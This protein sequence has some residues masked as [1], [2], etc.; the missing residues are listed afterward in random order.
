MANNLDSN[1]VRKLARIFLDKFEAARVLSKTVN[2]QLL[3]GK[4]NPASGTTT[5]FKRPTDYVSKRTSDGDISATDSSDIIAG[6]ATGTVQN[7][8]TVDVEWA[9][10]DEALKLDQL[11]ELLAP[12]AT[13]IVL[14]LETDFAAFM[15]ANAGLSTGSPDTSVTTWQHVANAG[16]LMKSVGIPADSP[17]HYAMNPFTQA[18]LANTNRALGSPVTGPVDQALTKATLIE[19]FAGM[20]VLAPSTL[21]TLTTTAISD[22]AGSLSAAPDVTYVTAKDSMTQSWAVTGFTAS[23]DVQAGEIVEVTGKFMTNL[24]TRKRFLDGAGNDV[25]FRGVVTAD[26]SLVG[27]GAGTLVVAGPGIFESGGA[28]NTTDAALASSDVVTLLGT[29]STTYQPNL[30]YHKN[31]FAIGSVPQKKLFSTDTIM[32]TKDGLQLRISKYADGDANTNKMR[33]D[34][35][36]AYAVLNPFFAGQGHA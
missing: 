24:A 25:K 15:L 11:D 31:A 4:F 13:R 34:L 26:A 30:F 22:R 36:P 28:Y 2:T 8:F 33:I 27:S 35:L 1:F 9:S 18:I 12:M 6:K 21:A 29:A 7:Y 17:W 3:T 20:K 32:T 14:D 5:D 10:V 16:A 19:N 23:L